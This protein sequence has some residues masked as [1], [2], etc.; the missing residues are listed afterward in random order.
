MGDSGNL[1]FG[2]GLSSN[3][4]QQA[5]QHTYEMSFDQQIEAVKKLK[6]LLDE[7]ILTEDEF[8]TKKKEIMGL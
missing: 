1:I 3:L 5:Q 6:E 8:N 7:G 4:G 2:M